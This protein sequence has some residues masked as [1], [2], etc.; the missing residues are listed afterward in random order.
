M[1]VSTTRVP[2]PNHSPFQPSS[3]TTDR[4]ETSCEAPSTCASWSFRAALMR[5][6]IVSPGCDAM[7]EMAPATTPHPIDIASCRAMGYSANEVMYCAYAHAF[8]HNM[9]HHMHRVIL[10]MQMHAWAFRRTSSYACTCTSGACSAIHTCICICAYATTNLSCRLRVFDFQ[11]RK[12]VGVHGVRAAG[13][14]GCNM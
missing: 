5:V 13:E 9:M 12:H 3:R 2:A 6:R 8:L 4:S 11:T 14:Y 1:L 10:E 7:L